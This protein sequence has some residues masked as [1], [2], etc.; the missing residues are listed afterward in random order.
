MEQDNLAPED[1][2]FF[3]A[4]Q[5]QRQ[6]SPSPA[7]IATK[8]DQ[9]LLKSCCETLQAL[10]GR[11]CG[12]GGA[13]WFALSWGQEL[14]RAYDHYKG[15]ND[16][17]RFN[18][19]VC[20][21]FHKDFSATTLVAASAI[22]L[23]VFSFAIQQAKTCAATYVQ[24][25]DKKVCC[26][27]C[28][29]C[30]KNLDNCL[31]CLNTFRDATNLSLGS[32]GAIWA[33]GDMCLHF[34]GKTYATAPPWAHYM[35][36]SV[37]VVTFIVLFIFEIFN[38]VKPIKENA[39]HRITQLLTHFE[40]MISMGPGNGAGLWAL[41]V[42]LTVAIIPLFSPG[43]TVPALVAKLIPGATCGLTIGTCVYNI[44]RPRTPEMD[45][46]ITAIK[47]FVRNI[48]DC[49]KAECSACSAPP[50][51]Y[52]YIGYSPM[53]PPKRSTEASKLIENQPL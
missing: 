49:V 3:T 40:T 5:P 13:P 50:I 35:F 33:H 1:A 2:K 42:M 24:N 37:S 25:N 4:N 51:K 14:V 27:K 43:F 15:T 53:R 20:S 47:S 18:T 28:A 7:N 9:D 30:C 6:A 46:L 11:D 12:F 21:I 52:E 39:I 44:K 48:R 36:A 17:S 41:Y 22:G 26:C 8:A 10:T 38:S 23:N 16:L 31:T 32:A 19:P 34:F 29:V 45:R